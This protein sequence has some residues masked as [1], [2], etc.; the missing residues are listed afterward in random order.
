MGDTERISAEEIYR[1]AFEGHRSASEFRLKV[2]GVWGASYAAL[3]AAFAWTARE[4]PNADWQAPM[5]G[6]LATALFW[7]ADRRNRDA[8]R[9]SRT[10]G[11]KVEARAVPATDERFFTELAKSK[12]TRHGWLIDRFALLAS[13]TLF[14]FALYRMSH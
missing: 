8:L 7:L 10:I 5:A 14:A 4:A 3:A 13:V 2:L 9:I 6:S 1:Q 12:E 11:E